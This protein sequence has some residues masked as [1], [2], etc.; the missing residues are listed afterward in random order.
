MPDL[1]KGGQASSVVEIMGTVGLRERRIG[2]A[3]Q[4][5]HG[6]CVESGREEYS[7]GHGGRGVCGED[8]YRCGL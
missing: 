4:D 1:H 7:K 3:Q 6:V 8:F 5:H 2:R